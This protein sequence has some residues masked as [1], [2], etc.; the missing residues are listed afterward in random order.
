MPSRKKA[1]KKRAANKK[2]A[3]KKAVAP[4]A[5]GSGPFPGYSRKALTWFRQIEKNNNRDWFLANKDTFENEVRAPTQAL[6]E[7][8]ARDLEKTAPAYAPLDARKALMRIYRDTR[9]SKD[10]TPYK[11][12]MS[13]KL[14]KDGG[15]PGDC[16]GFWF[17]VSK[18]GVD[19]VGGSYMPGGP[20]LQALR[21]YLAQH[22]AA[23]RKLLDRKALRE[24]MGALQGEALK[25]PPRGFDPEHPA[26]E[27]LKQKQFY[28]HAKL[29]A[30]LLTTPD[31]QK[32]LL[33]RFKLMVPV[34]E[35]LNTGM[36]A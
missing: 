19:V 30:A 1:A 26:I 24:A 17:A 3:T 12:S 27:L 29:P 10:K 2:A 31:L 35:F 8:L 4:R 20:Q 28:L 11:T 33:R 5:A 6:V 9:F 22:H 32:E 14:G 16:A 23:F 25:R 36:H 21:S 34:A 15:G 18:N 7:A 13:V